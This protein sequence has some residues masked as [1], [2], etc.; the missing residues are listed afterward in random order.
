MHNPILLNIIDMLIF[1]GLIILP[2]ALI[3]LCFTIIYIAAVYRAISQHRVSRKCYVL[4]LN[5]AIGDVLACLIAL[6][7]VI[8]VLSVAENIK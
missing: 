6:T 5:R 7:I 4:L 3:G 2:F 8:Y 1:L